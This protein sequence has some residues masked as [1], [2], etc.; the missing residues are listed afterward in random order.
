MITLNPEKE[1][2]VFSTMGT[3][4]E[5][6]IE[7][8]NPLRSSQSD[9]FR[10]PFAVTLLDAGHLIDAGAVKLIL[11]LSNDMRRWCPNL[12]PY[13]HVLGVIVDVVHVPVPNTFHIM[14]EQDVSRI[15]DDEDT[16]YKP[17][18]LVRM[19]RECKTI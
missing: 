19:Y 12:P 1:S 17:L 18:K 9:R 3:K 16:D 5:A 11:D 14:F 7:W 8:I 10:Y 4:N 2:A 13:I 15:L 6:S